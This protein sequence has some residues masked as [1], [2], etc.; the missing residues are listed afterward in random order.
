MYISDAIR[1]KTVCRLG[2]NKDVRIT[3]V[4]LPILSKYLMCGCSYRKRFWNK[5]YFDG[6]ADIQNALRSCYGEGKVS[7]IEACNRWMYHHSMLSQKHG[8]MLNATGIY[9]KNTHPV[10]ICFFMG[11]FTGRCN[12]LGPFPF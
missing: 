9:I 12:S 11:S 10:R 5:E 1:N 7:L 4:I 8:G 6:V 2:Y 3:V